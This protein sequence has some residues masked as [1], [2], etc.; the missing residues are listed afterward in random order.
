MT[1]AEALLSCPQSGGG[2]HSWIMTVS[3]ISAREGIAGEE[4][5]LRI[6]AAM[7]R[8]PTPAHEVEDSVSKAMRENGRAYVRN[9]YTAE[10]RMKHEEATKLIAARQFAQIA[11]DPVGLCRLQEASPVDIPHPNDPRQSAALLLHLFDRDE[12]VW[13]GDTFTTEKGIDTVKGWAQRLLLGEIT[14]PF[15][16]INPLTGSYGEKKGGG[17]SCRCDST[18]AAFRYALFEV[19][20]PQIPIELQAAFWLKMIHKMPVKAITYSGGKSL[21]AMIRVDCANEEEWDKK[22][23]YGCFP[24]WAKLGVDKTC[25][26]PSRLSRLAGHS[27]ENGKFQSLL[28]LR[29]NA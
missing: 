21:H 18:V 1:F 9:P 4:A 15:F 17:A 14:P 19:D 28:W 25:K 2:V 29:G 5:V 27:R 23:R 13:C 16:V 3:N 26:N 12:I 22:V 20:L 24:E 10:E 8:P 11:G 6:K 7:T